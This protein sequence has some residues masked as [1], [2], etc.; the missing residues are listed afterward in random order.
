MVN[1]NSTRVEIIHLVGENARSIRGIAEEFNTSHPDREPIHHTAISKINAIFV[2]T[3]NVHA[4]IESRQKK[5]IGE[6]DVYSNIP[7]KIQQPACGS[8]GIY[9]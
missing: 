4:N 8:N 2:L 5:L 3:G 7:D 1:Y 6:A 9:V